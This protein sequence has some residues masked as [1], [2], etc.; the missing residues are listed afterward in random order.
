MERKIEEKLRAWKSQQK[1]KA[2]MI[3]GPRQV[4]KS[5]IIREF[6][7]KN[8][9]KIIEINFE[10]NPDFKT[11]FENNLSADRL[12]LTLS[13]ML[14]G[15]ESFDDCLLFLD[16]I[17]GC[18][19]ALSAIK[20]LV[21][22][23]RCD[24]IC[25]G[26][27]LGNTIGVE[28]LT[29]LGYVEI[30]HMEPMDFEEFL[31]AI[32]FSHDKTNTIRKHIRTMEPFDR[33]VLRKLNDLF[34]R[35][36]TI[37]GM[38]EAVESFVRTGLYSESYKIQ[39]SIFSLL[40]DD[41]L[42]YCE[43]ST[44]KDRISQ[45]I[46]SIPRQLSRETGNSFRYSD[47]SMNTKYGRREYGASISWLVNAGFIDICYN[48][49]EISEPFVTKADGN[50]FKIY[51]KDTGMMTMML[52]PE[53]GR[54][55]VEGDFKINNGALIENAV[56]SAL[57]KNGYRLHYYSNLGK[58]IEIDFVANLNGRLAAIEVK[59]GR[60]KSA[61]S[62]NKLAEIGQDV[63][64]RIKISDSNLSVD[65]NGIYHIPL[66]GASFFDECVPL[67]LPSLD[68]SDLLN[69]KGPLS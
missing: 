36:V 22:D 46:S 56:A 32:G 7:K 55:I 37:G 21:S 30:I 17:Q 19:S 10:D 3:R 57:V 58:R 44:D 27:Q 42:R 4:G 50:T 35:Y 23:G 9:R 59:S 11:I 38:P 16:E 48:L 8:Y 28:R 12:F 41:I 49:E 47:V 45:C 2:L 63:D 20:P 53:I 34:L 51:V 66:F 54:G 62:L 61:R 15:V 6:G 29:P 52:G 24:I 31:W 39:S 60:K 68:I 65:E 64:V 40:R 25:S 14:E 43:S 69:D 5:Y 67:E 33:A 18:E 26:S 1:R 13:Y